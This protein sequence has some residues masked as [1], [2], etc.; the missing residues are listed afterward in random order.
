MSTD[1]VKQEKIIEVYRLP[2]AVF[3]AGVTDGC[4]DG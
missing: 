3:D 1:L 4:Q 2:V